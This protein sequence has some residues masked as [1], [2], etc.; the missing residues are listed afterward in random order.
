M[1]AWLGAA[2]VLVLAGSQ[3]ALWLRVLEPPPGVGLLDARVQ[4]ADARV[5]RL[6]QRPAPPDLAPLQARVAALEKRP[7]TS[8]AAAPPPPDLGPLEARI[9]A[10]EQR[11]PVTTAPDSND[12]LSQRLAAD[13]GRLATLEKAADSPTQTDRAN[14]TGRIQAAFIA[15]SM[16]QPLGALPGAPPALARYAT[17]APPTE[18]ALRL[19]FPAAVRAAMAAGHKAQPDEPF[20]R[21]AWAEVQDLITIRQGDHLVIGDPAAGVLAHAQ[22]LLDAG[23]LAGA[24]AAVASLSGPPAQ[25]LAPWLAQANGLLA[26]R[27]ALAD[28]AAQT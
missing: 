27:A 10:L 20:L 6:E 13:E 3:A 17:T 26:A 2:A 4:A 25:A 18:A 23:D 24:V 11:A 8:S 1:L 21:R 5:A 9:A 22:T 7:V 16:G 12:S 14:R 15:L 19:A 28:L